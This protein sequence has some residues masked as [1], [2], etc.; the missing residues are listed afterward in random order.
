MHVDDHAVL[1]R[2]VAPA[3]ASEIDD[4]GY[5]AVEVER[6]QAELGFA[7]AVKFAHAADRLGDVVHG[8]LDGAQVIPGAGTEVG[9]RIEERLGVER[10]RRD[11]VVDVVGD[12]AG[13]L[14][15]RAKPFL[16]QDRLLAL[17]KIIV[18]LLQG[19]VELG[20]VRCQRDVF[21][22]LFEELAFAAAE[23]FF[24][25]AG[26]DEDA[27]DLVFDEQRRRYERAQPAAGEALGKRKR[28]RF[29]IGFVN[30]FAADAAREPVFVDGDVGVFREG[31]FQREPLAVQADAVDHERVVDLVIK[32]HTAEIDRQVVFETA[33]NDLENAFEVLAFAGGARDLVK[34]GDAGELGFDARLG[35]LAFGDL[36]LQC[37][38]PFLD[39]GEHLVK[40]IREHAGLAAALPGGAHRVVLVLGDHLRGG[41]KFKERA[42]DR[43]LQPG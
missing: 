2:H 14:A 18:G 4:L 30:E 31:E 22:E 32:T 8:A 15:E 5:E 26:H 1:E 42:R 36:G 39:A 7:M 27:E 34:L 43:P 33:H 16:L 35:E 21:A 6:I 24:L 11:G 3:D 23:T 37:G 10:D 20:L 19:A 17:T 38:F 13:H 40:G 25:A 28:D 12:A 29:D 41:G 9:L